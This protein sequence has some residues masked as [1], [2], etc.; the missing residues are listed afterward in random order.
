MPGL[1]RIGNEFR[2]Q[3]MF[4]MGRRYDE[5]ELRRLCGGRHFDAIWVSDDGLLDVVYPLKR[6]FG[7]APVYVAGIN[8]AIT[9]VFRGAIR[10]V[11]LV[12]LTPLARILLV[13]KWLRSWRIGAIENS[14]LGQYDFVPI[15]SEADKRMLEKYPEAGWLTKSW[16]CQMA[17]T[18]VLFSVSPEK[19]RKDLLFV[20]SL[21]GMVLLSSGLWCMSGRP[22]V[23]AT[24]MQQ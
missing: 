7:E 16:S 4:H 14:L 5:T 15:Q 18:P 19:C 11:W 12:G 13:I 2:G 8:D 1:V 3:G 10:N 21:W 6:L 22:S 9:G 17:L 24:R 23:S 20:G